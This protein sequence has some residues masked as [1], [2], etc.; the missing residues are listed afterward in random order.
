MF[1][2]GEKRFN[3]LL[4]TSNEGTFLTKWKKCWNSLLFFNRNKSKEQ[5]VN[6]SWHCVFPPLL[7][8]GSPLALVMEQRVVPWQGIAAVVR[9]ICSFSPKNAPCSCNG[10]FAIVC[11]ICGT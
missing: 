8:V 1:G 7:P 9:F 11:S 3:H 4:K 10:R 5:Q 2:S 6:G